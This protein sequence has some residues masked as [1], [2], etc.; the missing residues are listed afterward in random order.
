VVDLDD[1]L[2]LPKPMSRLLSIVREGAQRSGAPVY[3][4]RTHQ[5]FFRYLVVRSSR[6]T[7]K[8]LVC[9]ITAPDRRESRGT[10]DGRAVV[11]ALAEELQAAHAGPGV[12][13][14]LDV[15]RAV[16]VGASGRIFDLAEGANVLVVDCTYDE[17]GPEHMGLDDVRQVRRRVDPATTVILTHLDGDPDVTG[18]DNVIVAQDFATYRFP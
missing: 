5:G 14:A 17:A 16:A 9:L 2:L 12:G 4:P 13:V 11:E 8:I 3:S 10:R 15:R 1:C 6:A 18:L 7:G